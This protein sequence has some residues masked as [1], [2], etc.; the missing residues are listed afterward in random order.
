MN[1]RIQT[2][3]MSVRHGSRREMLLVLYISNVAN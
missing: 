3:G 2:V 1:F